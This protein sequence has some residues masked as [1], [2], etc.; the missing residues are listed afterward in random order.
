[1]TRDTI[2]VPSTQEKI[3]SGSIGYIEIA[4]FGEHTREEFRKSFQ[5]LVSSGATGIILD[6]RNNGGGYLDSA[7]D[8]LS[9]LLPD[10]KEAVI[11]R[12]NDLKKTQTLFTRKTQNT[13]EKI[14]L[15]MI[16]NGLSA[17][18]TEIVA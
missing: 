12:E 10:K 11:T 6:F 13:N 5:N 14:P 9:F 3:L 2:I 15:V 1:M 18:A 4:F 17:S 8:V 16:V 7:V